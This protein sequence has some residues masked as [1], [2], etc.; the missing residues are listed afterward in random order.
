MPSQFIY[1]PIGLVILSLFIYLLSLIFK[2]RKKG[3]NPSIK[4]RISL[5][6]FLI[7]LIFPLYYFLIVGSYYGLKSSQSQEI[8]YFEGN[9][10]IYCLMTI[11]TLLLYIVYIFKKFKKIK[12]LCT[13][14]YP[15]TIFNIYIA[16]MYILAVDSFTAWIVIFTM[17]IP[18]ILGF[19]ALIIGLIRDIRYLKNNNNNLV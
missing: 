10:M 13:L 14:I 19:I 3:N 18:I 6:A 15:L 9:I 17:L 8:L 4:S 1:L 2:N 12:Y 7:S 5:Y 11:P 16:I